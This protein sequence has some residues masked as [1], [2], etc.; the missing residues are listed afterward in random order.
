[1]F[2]NA[3][4]HTHT[5]AHTTSSNF[6]GLGEIYEAEYVRAATGFAAPDKQE[7][8]RTQAAGLFKALCAKLDALSSFAY[9]PKPVVT[10]LEVCAACCG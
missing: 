9:A 10:E 2:T 3:R 1:L 5:H 8:L 6:Q 7:G 4:T